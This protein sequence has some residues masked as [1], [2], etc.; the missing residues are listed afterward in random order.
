MPLPAAWH[1]VPD[2]GAAR[3]QRPGAAA[4]A[5]S[6]V[7]GLPRGGR[8][9]QW[10]VCA[11]HVREVRCRHVRDTFLKI[12]LRHRSPARRMTIVLDNAKHRRAVL[13]KPL[14]RKYRAVLSLLFPPP[15]SP[16]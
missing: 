8:S 14:L 5:D 9:E 11:R 7:G 1:A 13:L 2:V 10:Q 12:L 6:Q 4:C 15:C 16:N 3:D